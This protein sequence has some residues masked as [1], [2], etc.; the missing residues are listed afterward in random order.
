MQRYI[1]NF[2]CADCQ[3][4]KPD[5]KGYGMLPIMRDLKE[6]PFEE[7]AVD[8]IG[9]CKVQVRDKAYEFN[10]LTAIDTVT[11][12]VDIF[13]IDQNKHQNTS[14]PDLY[15]IGWQGIIGLIAVSMTM[16]VDL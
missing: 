13:R 8:L 1:D 6:Q 16:V 9:P 2:A 10:A 12:L 15:N 14:Q 5:G 7:V 3:K 11:N 4:H